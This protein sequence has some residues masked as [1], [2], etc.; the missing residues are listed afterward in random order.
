MA[1]WVVPHMRMSHVRRLLLNVIWLSFQ[2]DLIKV[3]DALS[4]PITDAHFEGCGE[5]DPA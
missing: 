4:D 2:A 1:L 3:T 5:P